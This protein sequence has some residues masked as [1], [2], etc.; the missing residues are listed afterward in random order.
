M[1]NGNKAKAAKILNIP[2]TTLYY[3]IDQY[4]IDVSKI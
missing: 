4:K 3:K 1:S 2:R